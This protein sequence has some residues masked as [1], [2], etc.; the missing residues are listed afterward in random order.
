MTEGAPRTCAHCGLPVPAERVVDGADKLFC[1]SGCEAVYR[2][3]G[4]AGLSRYYD[5]RAADLERV[6][7]PASPSAA[8]FSEL[9]DPEFL[10]LHASDAGGGKAVDLYLEGVHCAACVWL[11]EKL[12]DL[13]AGVRS[14]RLD[15]G[16]SVASIEWD[17]KVTKLSAV[18]RT[19]DRFGYVPHP[20]RSATRRSLA[21]GE[22]RSMLIRMG[23]AGAAAGNTMLMAVALYAGAEDDPTMAKFLRWMSLIVAVPAVA[24]AGQ[25]FFRGALA[26]LRTRTLHM[27][28]PVSVA[29][30]TATSASVYSTVTG[31]G[32]V[33]FDSLSMLVFLLLVARWLQFRALRASADASELLFS[34]AP[35]RARVVDDAGAER[36]VA[37]DTLVAGQRVAIRAGESVPVDGVVDAGES[38]LDNALLTGESAPVEVREGDQVHAGALN[39]AARIVVRVTAAG[40][41]TRVGKLLAAVRAAQQRR[42]PIV[43][44]ADRIAVY[45]VAA[46]LA[47]AALSAGL[48]WSHGWSVVVE[49]FVSVLVVTCPCALG[50]ATPLAVAHALGAAARHGIFVKG[51]DTIEA[52]AGISG[53]VFDKTGT[54]TEGRVV[55]TRFEGPPELRQEIAAIEAHSSHPYARA[56]VESMPTSLVADDVRDRA[57]GGVDGSVAG[58]RVSI[59]T[60]RFLRELGVQVSEAWERRAAHA[61]ATEGSPVLVARDG[62]VCGLMTFGDPLRRES[63]AAVRALEGRGLSVS[64]L[65]GDHPGVVARVAKELGVQDALGGVPPERKLEL[66]D[67][68]TSAGRNLAMVGDGVNDAAALAAAR[69]GIAVRG[70]AEACLASADVFLTRPGVEPVVH[71]IDGARRTLRVVYRGLA[72]S[73]VYNLIGASLALAGLIDPLAAAVLMPISS[74]TVVLSSMLSRPFRSRSRRDETQLVHAPER[75][76]VACP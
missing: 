35:S 36:E 34:L 30:I 23:V 15:F 46:V 18:A 73:L 72:I 5:L 65:S 14:V 62:S 9:D 41:N 71:L 25:T 27:D 24:W 63:C 39:V 22:E 52:L 59:G 49:R 64:I 43:Q 68:W 4:E 69:V 48:W 32:S 53:V 50:L 38:R 12:P 17:P 67:G 26:G 1:C 76:V 57:G 10:R 70:G 37:V 28:V 11:V 40:E 47:L 60:L 33:Y 56:V 45:F 29:L 3:I 75:E 7:E 58:H 61:A 21:K 2:V 51:A 16:R 13:V 20:Y 66:V 74:L 6:L 8:T 42:A 44:L 54:L 55:L 19:L 31:A